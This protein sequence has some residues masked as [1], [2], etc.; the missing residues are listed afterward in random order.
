MSFGL[1]T[2]VVNIITTHVQIAQA[3]IYNIV[4]PLKIQNLVI[5]FISL[6][7]ISLKL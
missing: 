1:L 5:E 2:I 7:V 6:K 3:Y 4:T